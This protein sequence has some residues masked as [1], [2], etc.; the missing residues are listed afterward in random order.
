MRM[1][2]VCNSFLP[3]ARG[4]GEEEEEEENKYKIVIFVCH[5]KIRKQRSLSINFPDSLEY[6]VCN[7]SLKKLRSKSNLV[8]RRKAVPL[9]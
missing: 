9:Q 7:G 8:T 3:E 4:K 5:F 1:P 2:H 6:A